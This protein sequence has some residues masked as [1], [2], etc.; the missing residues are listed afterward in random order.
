[1]KNQIGAFENV[2]DTQWV[3]GITDVK[4]NTVVG[5]L[6]PELVLLG[7]IPTKNPNLG[8]TFY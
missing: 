1:V 5:Y 4:T 2:F 8:C 3:S 7:F 6:V